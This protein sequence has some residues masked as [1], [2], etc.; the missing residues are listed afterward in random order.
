MF[1][2]GFQCQCV[3]GA[4]ANIQNRQWNVSGFTL[5]SRSTRII[6]GSRPKPTTV[7]RKSE[8][9]RGRSEPSADNPALDRRTRS[10]IVKPY[11]DLFDTKVSM[12]V[13][14]SVLATQRLNED[15]HKASISAR[16]AFHRPSRR[17]HRP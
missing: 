4:H 13:Y 17:I 12:S 6:C 5:P 10:P 2:C 7:P 1:D 3:G 11:R 14:P 16:T 15:D 8:L 9:Y